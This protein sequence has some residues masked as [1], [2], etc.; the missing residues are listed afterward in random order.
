MLVFY[1]EELLAPRPT[2]KLEDHPLSAVRDCLF[3]IFTATLHI[4]GH[5]LH[6][7]PEDVPYHGDKG[8]T[9][10]VI[11]YYENI[12]HIFLVTCSYVELYSELCIMG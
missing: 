5:H 3:N 6:L 10:M 1:G 4:G 12:A 11:L 7:Q 2:P 8:T 9:N